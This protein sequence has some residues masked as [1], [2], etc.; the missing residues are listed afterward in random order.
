M[1][2]NYTRIKCRDCG[3]V[4]QIETKQPLQCEK[5]K[6]DKWVCF[7]C[8]SEFSMKEAIF[9]S[10]C[11]WFIC[12]NCG[13]CRC[14]INPVYIC[15][16]PNHKCPYKKVVKDSKLVFGLMLPEKVYVEG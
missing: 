1:A 8:G 11:R 10:K 13:T 6:N 16:N 5:C 12:P 7:A 14:N 4:T 9:C 15:K 2:R 3:H